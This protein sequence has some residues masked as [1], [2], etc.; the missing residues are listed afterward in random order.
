[1]QGSVRILI[2]MMLLFSFITHTLNINSA[3]LIESRMTVSDI[4]GLTAIFLF[5]LE[6]VLTKEST[7]A[8]PTLYKRAA[9]AIVCVSLS[10]VTSLSYKSTIF[11]LL[12]VYYLLLLS[13]VMYEVYKNHIQELISILVFTTFLVSVICLYDFVAVNSG[14][15]TIFPYAEKNFGGSSFRYFGQAANYS[16]TFLTILIPLKYSRLTHDFSVSK[17]RFLHITIVLAVLLLFSTARVS[18]ILSF[19]ISII[20]FL[21]Y[22]R[23]TNI[24]KDVAWLSL[25]MLCSM[26]LV[27]YKFPNLVSNLITRFQLRITKREEGNLASDFIIDNFNNT[28]VSFFDNPL[29]GSGLG[30][31]LNNYSKYEIHGTYLK[32]IGETGLVG[33]IGYLIFIFFFIK[34]LS[35]TK[36]TFFY[37]FLPFLIGSLVSWGY[38][39]HLRKKEFWILFAFLAIVQFNSEKN[40]KKTVEDS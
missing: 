11:E 25:L 29:F 14:L 15:M 28:F 24:V 31:F 33:L 3:N 2:A 35:K 27:L 23:K 6:R 32:M 19:L 30:G 7:F 9:V 18:I 8:I 13:Y 4:F 12:I 40:K 21:L 16:F 22:T 5:F 20:C 26:I 10:I 1:M 34:V 37:F 36:N 39:Y 38:N 17:K